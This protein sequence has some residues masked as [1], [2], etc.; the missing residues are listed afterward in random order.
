[1]ATGRATAAAPAPSWSRSVAQAGAS[2][3]LLAY[4]H[5]TA[6]ILGEYGLTWRAQQPSASLCGR[7]P[8][9]TAHSVIKECSFNSSR[10]WPWRPGR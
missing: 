2:A 9:D 8:G 3:G 5:E 4:I 6:I 1:M 7:H 10:P